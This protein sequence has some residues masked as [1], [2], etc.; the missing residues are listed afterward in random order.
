M[1]RPN[2]LILTAALTLFIA[3]YGGMTLL[4]GGLYLDTHEGD[5]YHLLDILLRMESGRVLHQDFSTPL[6]ILTFA[7]ILAFMKAGIPVGTAIILAQ[8]S[9]A[10]LLLPLVVYAAL[11]RM[12]RGVAYYF[13][14]VTLGLALALSF[15]G[16]VSGVTI[17]MHYNRWAWSIAFVILALA[18]LPSKSAERPALDGAIIGVLFGALALL[19]MTFFV[20]LAPGV[21]VAV[22]V[23]WKG[24]GFLAA[25][26]GGLGVAAITTLWMGVS[27]WGGYL[28]DLQSV[29]GSEVRSNVGVP[30]ND[31]ISGALYIGATLVGVASV[32]LIR[33]A[34][35]DTMALAILL[36]MPGFIFI[37]YQNFGNDPQWV[38]IL[39]VLLMSLRPEIGFAALAGVDL[40]VLMA[41]A[42]WMAV[43]LNFPSFVNNA[44][45]PIEHVAFDK[46]R[47]VPMLPAERGHQ[48]IY[49]RVDRAYMMTAQVFKDLE[50]EVWSPYSEIV[51]RAP[52]QEFGGITVPHC[53]WMAG[54]KAYF[55]VFTADLVT[56]GIPAGSQ[57]FTADILSGFWLFGPFEPLQG[58]APWYYSGLAGFQNAD[59]VLIPKCSFVARVR[60]IMIKDLKASG[61][62]FNLVRD[63]E[64]Y[65][66]FSIVR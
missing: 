20:S 62:E 40:R 52:L 3:V 14:L 64:L 48:D 29:T 56:S 37:S 39:P 38:W 26:I 21:A 53:E 42:A 28:G 19:K 5:S 16:P 18:L 59:Y 36:L 8:L 60:G 55:E 54:S 45:S 61:A 41:S 27:F 50:Q 63:N 4:K 66:L 13:G 6:G 30:L 43:A 12:S 17:S 11:T 25:L 33:R 1:S 44:S 7:P 65:A 49:I 10:I 24:R 57:I 58:G 46:D 2:P 23:H 35:H 9:V 22:L 47:F 34:G 31:I 32:L 15:G 51:E